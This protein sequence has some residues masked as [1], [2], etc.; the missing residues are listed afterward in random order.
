MERITHLE[1]VIKLHSTAPAPFRELEDRMEFR[2]EKAYEAWAISIISGVTQ[3]FPLV[4]S[5][6]GQK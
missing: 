3:N 2:L 6:T 4:I 1:E 5:G